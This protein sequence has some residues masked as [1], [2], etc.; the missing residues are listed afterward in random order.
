MI[1]EAVEE[2][3][4]V[5]IIHEVGE[6]L[7]DGLDKREEE[8]GVEIYP[9]KEEIKY[10]VLDDDIDL[11]WRMVFEDK[12]GRVE[13]KKVL[14]HEN[15][16]DVYNLDKEE[17]MK[18]GYSVQINEKDRDKVIWEVVDDHV[19]EEW[20]EHEEIGIEGFDFNIFDEDREGCVEDNV[21]EFPYF[22]ML[23]KL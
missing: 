15:R 9:D 14:L 3:R 7:E 23:I 22:L 18:D 20:V 19:V 6:E 13:G 2:L 8:V 4:E 12:N 11:H 10:V 17:L 16:W 21:K 5:D 1:P